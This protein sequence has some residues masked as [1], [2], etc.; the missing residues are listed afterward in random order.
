[1]I[2]LL[3]VVTAGDP[4][5]SGVV[6]D[7]IGKPAAGAQIT[8]SAW[9]FENSP[10]TTSEADGRFSL[11]MLKALAHNLGTGAVVA[12]HVKHGF[13]VR[14]LYETEPGD[15]AIHFEK[16]APTRIAIKD[17]EGKPFK[18]AKA[19]ASAI[20]HEYKT[21]PNMLAHASAETNADGVAE[22]KLLARDQISNLDV[23]TAP[24]VVQSFRAAAG[25]RGWDGVQLAATKQ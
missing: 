9:T 22:F 19:M 24:D 14:Q 15:F 6:R 18:H 1:M 12:F 13:A 8:V 20:F 17:A 7:A 3:L 4:M 5:I 16:L 23:E 11:P 2:T 25:L 10:T 21:P